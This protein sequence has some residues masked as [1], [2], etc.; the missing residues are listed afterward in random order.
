M[1]DSYFG[2]DESGKQYKFDVLTDG[3][4]HF[5]TLK[6]EAFVNARSLRVLGEL[7][8][9]TAGDEGYVVLPRRISMLGDIQMFFKPRGDVTYTYGQ[10]IMSYYGIKREGLCCIVRIER[11]YR[12]AFEVTVKDNKYT[13]T[14]VFDFTAHDK[15]YDDI[16][17]EIVYLPSEAG[18]AEM[19]AAER[20][21]RL[22][23]GEIRTLREKCALPAVEYARKYP[24]VR[25]RM[26]W[27]PSPSPVE[28]QTEANEPE[29][30]A[31]CDFKRVRDI[32]DEL[33]RQGVEGA[34][35]QLVGWNRGGHDGRYPQLFPAEPLLG[36]NKGLAETVD[37]VKKLGYTISAHTN[38]IDSYEIGDTFRWDDL[39]VARNG[40]YT[41][42]DSYG[43]GRAYHVCLIKQLKN[44]LRDLP[45]LAAYGLNGLHYTDV[46]SIVCPDDC[47]DPNHPSSTSNSIIYAQKIMEW[48][49]GRFGGFSSEGCFDFAMKDMDFGLYATM[50]TSKAEIP[51][52]DRIL[53]LFEL[54]YHGT[55]LYNPI[56]TTV[57][58]TAQSPRDRLIMIMRGGRPAMYFYSKFRV[59]TGKAL[60]GWMGENDL[61]CDTEEQL[62]WSVGKVKEAAEEYLPL[63]GKQL[64]YMVGY[65]FLDDGI[66]IARYSDG[67][68]I[69]GNFSDKEASYE[70]VTLPAWGY[71]VI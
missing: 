69:M 57:N 39:V 29:M 41:L 59:G 17:I 33:K 53:P 63:A 54:T 66:E 21:T 58:Y 10:P 14:P 30:Y 38:T 7:S 43:G 25:I 62:K 45:A 71:A 44:T 3:N 16:R 42:G 40:E 55:V 6:K 67:S 31:A 23:R 32:A 46:I 15:V 61:I 12:Y 56:A 51:I 18:Y 19:A 52:C 49:R 68:A 22:A 9:A 11:S 24:V 64:L 37:H 27:K 47:H 13:V 60:T 50:G 26:G 35:L 5:L 48:T 36:G 4:R 70:G 20:E 65:D 8:A 34:E 1:F 28:H 2:V